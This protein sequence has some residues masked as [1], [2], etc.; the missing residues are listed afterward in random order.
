MMDVDIIRTGDGTIRVAGTPS[1]R[2]PG[3]RG[4]GFTQAVLDVA[5]GLLTWPRVD[6]M[7]LPVAEIDD[8]RDAQQWLWAV[9]GEPVSIACA[10]VDL[11]GVRVPAEEPKLAR[12]AARLAFRHWAARWWPARRMIAET[13]QSS[14]PPKGCG[15]QAVSTR[16]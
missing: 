11:D 4:P 15:R 14:V 8:V 12:D 2:D 7:G 9:Y 16:C 13:P 5:G 1:E 6:N 3:E 10:S